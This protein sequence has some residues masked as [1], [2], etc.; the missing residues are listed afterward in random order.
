MAK[1]QISA[2]R[3]ES[4]AYERVAKAITESVDRLGGIGRF[5]KPGQRVLLKP[6]LLIASPA[7]KGVTTHPIVVKA[8]I[9]MVRKAGGI[10]SIGD[11]PGFGT[12]RRVAVKA[13]IALAA[14][15]LGC[16]I[17]D[18]RDTIEVRT[19]EGYTFRRFEVARDVVGSD[20]VI[21]LPRIKTHGQMLLTLGVKNMFGCIPGN[22][23]AAWH[24]KAG[25]DRIYFARLL[26]ELYSILKPALTIVDG[27]VGMEGNGPSAGTLKPIHT[28]F[29]GTDCVALDSTITHLLGLPRER[30]WTTQVASKAAIGIADPN[31]IEVLGP[32][33]RDLAIRDFRLPEAMTGVEWGL[34]D[35]LKR[36]LKNGLLPRPDIDRTRCTECLSCVAVCSPKAME[37]KSGGVRID[38]HRC[39]RCFCCQEVCTGGA[40]EISP[41]LLS[42]AGI[43]HRLSRILC[44]GQL[45][46]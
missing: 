24:L 37:K 15:E 2:V 39:I 42:R 44:K 35:F 45:S 46:P 6:N 28:V 7:D 36:V 29:A 3:C 14:D 32:P 31:S 11:S 27:I 38:L 9:Q 8:V 4:Y 19:P 26:V 13:G 23:K 22:R 34:P 5:V 12:A 21:S 10:P 40:I 33:L 30:L 41:S 25:M 20:V 1:T 43:A 18:F 17:S 16:P